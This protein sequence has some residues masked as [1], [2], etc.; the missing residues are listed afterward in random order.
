MRCRALAL[1]DPPFR[2]ISQHKI[3]HPDLPLR[4][5]QPPGPE[6]RPRERLA[7]TSDSS[8]VDHLVPRPS[9]MGRTTGDVVVDYSSNLHSTQRATTSPTKA[10][11]QPFRWAAGPSWDSRS[12]WHRISAIVEASGWDSPLAEQPHLACQH[13]VPL[14]GASLHSAVDVVTTQGRTHLA[15]V[16]GTFEICPCTKAAP[17]SSASLFRKRFC[18]R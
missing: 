14:S 11:L 4:S 10:H 13:S 12:P 6:S 9:K 5:Y 7:S 3:R 8:V 1:R 2:L 17:T 18:S 15:G 16:L